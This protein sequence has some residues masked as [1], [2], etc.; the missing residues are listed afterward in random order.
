MK[1]LDKIR[2]ELKQLVDSYNLDGL[3]KDL[4]VDLVARYHY[5]MQFELYTSIYNNFMTLTYNDDVAFAL[6][7]EHFYSVFR[8]VPPI[9]RFKCDAIGT[10]SIKKLQELYKGNKF[11]LY[12]AKDMFITQGAEDI[13]VECYVSR[14]KIIK[15]RNITQNTYYIDMLDDDISEVMNIAYP[16]GY[17]PVSTL[18]EHMNKDNSILFITLPSFAVRAYDKNRFSGID[19]VVFEAIEYFTIDMLDENELNRVKIDGLKIKDYIVTRNVPRELKEKFLFKVA[20]NYRIGNS[21]LSN[22]DILILFGEYFRD[23]VLDSHFEYNQQLDEITI[24]Y[25]RRDYSSTPIPTQQLNDFVNKYGRYYITQNISFNL[26]SPTIIYMLFEI[27]YDSNVVNDI[28]GLVQNVLSKYVLMGTEVD[29][30]EIVAQ[31]VNNEGVSL[32]KLYMSLTPNPSEQNHQ[33]KI[34]LIKPNYPMFITII[35]KI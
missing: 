18:T 2:A 4:L 21:I 35:N 8:G 30:D 23:I 20:Q 13:Y 5:N 26:V 33:H 34:T 12:A 25:S 27:R 11:N 31:L 32:V 1:P 14:R 17:E 22:S 15:Q 3:V 28:Q 6:A 9:V 7:H 19:K 29:A 24:Y 16:S 10:L